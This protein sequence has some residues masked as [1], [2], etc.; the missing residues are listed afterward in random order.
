MNIPSE[1]RYRQFFTQGALPNVD[2]SW[3]DSEDLSWAD[4]LSEEDDERVVG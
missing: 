4:K 1:P 3:I 2:L